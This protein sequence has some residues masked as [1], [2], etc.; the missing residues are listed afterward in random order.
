MQLPVARAVRSRG[1]AIGSLALVLLLCLLLSSLALLASP[2]AAQQWSALF[3][4]APVLVTPTQQVSYFELRLQSV[5]AQQKEA[6][7][8][9]DAESAA[10]PLPPLVFTWTNMTGAAMDGSAIATDAADPAPWSSPVTPAMYVSFGDGSAPNATWNAFSAPS[11]GFIVVPPLAFLGQSYTVVAVDLGDAFQYGKSKF[12]MLA[13]LFQPVDL[14]QCYPQHFPFPVA[15]VAAGA[16]A[17][18]TPVQFIV[19]GGVPPAKQAD[20]WAVVLQVATPASSSSP[21]KHQQLLQQRQAQDAST[22]VSLT[23]PATADSAQWMAF[24]NALLKIVA[25]DPQWPGSG[26]FY[27]GVGAAGGQA[28]GNGSFVLLTTGSSYCNAAARKPAPTTIT[29]ELSSRRRHRNDAPLP[30]AAIALE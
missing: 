1:G 4:G 18:V 24:N 14:S 13:Q 6:W 27:V 30:S 5:F 8:A 10:P 11:G 21:R 15:T 22:Y 28:N 7:G 29:S 2:V 25:N 26:T 23:P 9:I 19:P 16:S 20:D 3:D 17:S 12:T